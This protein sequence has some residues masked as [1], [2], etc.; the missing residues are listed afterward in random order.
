M[1][2]RK[3]I[4]STVWVFLPLFLIFG[5]F[6]PKTGLLAVLC[7]SLPVL[8]AFFRGR[9]W[10]GHYCPRGSLLDLLFRR[11][12]RKGLPLG[13][14]ARKIIR[15]GVFVILMTLFAVQLAMAKSVGEAGNVFIRMV[16]IT[17]AAALVLGA[18]FGRRSWC[19]VC[20]MG[21]LA[22]AASGVSRRVKDGKDRAKEER[23]A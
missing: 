2:S 19:S 10:C 11:V 4:H 22:T 5:I 9:V 7:M 6:F 20:P 15:Y 17:T 18:F 1:F 3:V 21:T 23:A 16:F 13:T 8:V 14:S 12:S